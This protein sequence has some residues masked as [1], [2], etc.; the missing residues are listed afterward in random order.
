MR[1]A[2]VL[3]FALATPAAWSQQAISVRAGLVHYLEG[4]AHIDGTPIK[5]DRS[6][7]STVKDGGT[8]TT[9][10][11]MAEVLL[12]PGIFMRLAN[13][14][15][16]KMVSGLLSD[17]K[18]EMI[19]G[20]ALVEVLEMG[21]E[22]KVEMRIGNSASLIQKAGLYSFDAS[23]GSV[24]V[25]DGKML[26]SVDNQNLELGKGR[27]AFVGQ[28]LAASK[29]P[30]KTTNSLYDWSKTRSAMVAYANIAASRTMR[31]NGYR[32][33][34]SLW[35]Y[36]PAYGLVT[37]LPRSGYIRS[38]FGWGWY[39]PSSVWQ[40]YAGAQGYSGGGGNGGGGASASSSSWGGWGSRGGGGGM[41]GGGSYS[42]DGGF[43]RS[44]SVSA[45]AASSA[46]AA[47]PAAQSAPGGSRGR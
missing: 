24:R 33:T 10:D 13:Q 16:M 23:N 8:L 25:F 15:S 5:M 46:P 4:T 6:K 31:D 42:G 36:Y 39:N 27:E 14:S 34:N 11:G 19:K 1:I 40:Y 9:G 12:A 38:P 21:K 32:V 2:A 22:N 3:L 28:T 20:S 43:S 44:S 37:Y 35:A 47:A 29:F 41:S 45:P 18:I 30:T 17:T 7:F 26:V